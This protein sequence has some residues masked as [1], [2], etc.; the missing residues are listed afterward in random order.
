MQAAI[1]LATERQPTI[2]ETFLEHT[3]NS[4]VNFK[5][6]KAYLVFEVLCT[7]DLYGIFTI[8]CC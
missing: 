7:V 3:L 5:H 4:E 6:F 8:D 2:D 1:S